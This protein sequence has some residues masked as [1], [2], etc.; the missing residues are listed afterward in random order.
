M[1]PAGTRPSL[2]L[3]VLLDEKVSTAQRELRA[4]DSIITDKHALL[5]SKNGSHD[6]DREVFSPDGSL[7]DEPSPLLFI[8]L[9]SHRRRVFGR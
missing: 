8:C 7:P 6:G 9:D 2:M 1:T 5:S 4:D 3:P